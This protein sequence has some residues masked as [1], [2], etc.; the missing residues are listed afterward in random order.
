[1]TTSLIV[2]F[3]WVLVFVLLAFLS[4]FRFPMNYPIRKVL[5]QEV[6]LPPELRTSERE[7]E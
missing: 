3:I 4:M 6:K 1:M 7:A 2:G 5:G